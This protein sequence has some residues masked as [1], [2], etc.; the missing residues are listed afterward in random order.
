[1]LLI[2]YFFVIF[3]MI[4]N[5]EA[6]FTSG[7]FPV[8]ILGLYIFTCLVIVII[9]FCKGLKVRARVSYVKRQF[10]KSRNKI[11]AQLKL[12]HASRQQRMI[13]LR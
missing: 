5:V 3:N 13:D 9:G 4:V 6:N 7:Y 11:R 2:C 1:M 10:K 12:N 8:A